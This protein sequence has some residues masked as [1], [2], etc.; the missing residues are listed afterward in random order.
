MTYALLSFP[1]LPSDAALLHMLGR[2]MLAALLGGIIG[3]ERELKHRPA[4]LRTN[5]FICL[6]AAM[7][8]MLSVQL[9]SPSD[10]TRIA[11]QIIPGIGFIGAGSI[12]RSRA[13]V[14]G[15]TTAATIFVVASIGMASGGGLYR[16]AIFATILIVLCLL[17]LGAVETR[18]NLKPLMMHYT[19]VTEMPGH[20]CLVEIK[21]IL[22]EYEKAPHGARINKIEDKQ[23]ISFSVDGTRK[24]H[25]T[26]IERLREAHGISQIQAVPGQEIE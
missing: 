25:A 23:R 3:L 16:L 12:I 15:L 18:F 17:A 1:S 20:D 6:G 8:T 10:A 11:S 5:M 9:A 24:E 2:L 21:A 22:D 13:G 7:F 19:I 4:G 26:I 14:S